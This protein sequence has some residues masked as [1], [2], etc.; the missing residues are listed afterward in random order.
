[1]KPTFKIDSDERIYA[2][3][4]YISNG[5]WMVSRKAAASK[6]APPALRKL[7]GI[8]AGAYPAGYSP[9]REARAGDCPDFSGVLKLA[10]KAKRAIWMDGP[11]GVNFHRPEEPTGK[12]KGKRVE[13]DRITAYIF[14]YNGEPSGT[15]RIGIAPRYVP[16]LRM[17]YAFA[18][19]ERSAIRVCVA[20][21][22]AS[23]LVAVIMPVRL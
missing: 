6:T 10:S 18:A 20:P 11:T 16:I 4:D 13:R 9:R 3:A 2:N 15:Q 7:A 1:M 17:G 12:D 21:D 23:E 19:D 14:G 22:P 5:H 8:P